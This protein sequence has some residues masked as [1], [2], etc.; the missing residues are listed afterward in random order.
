VTLQQS[1]AKSPRFSISQITTLPSSFEDDL[2]IY[3][4]AGAE[5]IGIWEIKLEEGREG[6]QLEAL[7]SSGLESTNAI[8]AVPSI[9]PIPIPGAE[10]PAVRV[11]AYCDGLRRLAPFEPSA[12]VL[13][14]GVG[15]RR[16]VVA[17]MRRIAAEARSL[18]LRIALEP[19][20]RHG[21]AEWTIINTIPEA[22][23]LI[24]E[25]GVAEDVGILFDIWHLWDCP[26]LEQHI[27][28]E[29][30]RIAGVHVDDVREQTRSFADR[31]LP[32]DGIAE[33]PRILAALD[34]A[35]WQGFYD[36]EIFSDNGAFGNAFP[37]SLW[38][39]APAELARRGREAF[40]S[41][42]KQAETA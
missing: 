33:V 37:D 25:A 2:R 10:D 32:G 4:E 42:W 3:R 9:T 31:V 26:N 18:G 28:D 12:V 39:V 6:Q 36:L 40:L 23:E 38:D 22:V 13:L 30:G 11:E 20:S 5:G 1:V 41:C 35:G 17:G 7:R 19:Y 24:E 34:R 15:E 14:T 27:H 16:D 21:G 8:P 29:I